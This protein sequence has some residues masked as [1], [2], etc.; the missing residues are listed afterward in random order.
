MIQKQNENTIQRRL[1]F[2]L[3]I[4][5]CFVKFFSKA[6]LAEKVESLWAKQR[7]SEKELENFFNSLIVRL[8]RP[9]GFRDTIARDKCRE[10]V[11][12]VGG[13]NKI[14]FKNNRFYLLFTKGSIDRI[15][16]C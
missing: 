8:R 16:L 12:R 9:E 7:E 10:G 4:L 6:A 13:M 15:L 1:R 14:D 3:S 2:S 11:K 5:S